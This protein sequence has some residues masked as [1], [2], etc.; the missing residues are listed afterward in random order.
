MR[1]IFSEEEVDEHKMLE[2]VKR[3]QRVTLILKVSVLSSAERWL[4]QGEARTKWHKSGTDN[5]TKTLRM[6]GL[7]VG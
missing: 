2:I 3:M 4:V 6:K 5:K 1:E 7:I